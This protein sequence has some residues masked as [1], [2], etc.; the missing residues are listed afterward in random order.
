MH[1][2][3]KAHIHIYIPT[4][5]HTYM[6]FSTHIDWENGREKIWGQMEDLL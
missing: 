1:I 4:Y 3:I 5:I 6:D 2:Y